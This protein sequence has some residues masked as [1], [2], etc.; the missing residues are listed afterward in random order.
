VER[1]IIRGHFTLDIA[2]DTW[3]GPFTA[4]FLDANGAELQVVPGRA[5]GK[6]IVAEPFEME[7]TPVA[8]G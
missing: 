6:R 1:C 4:T 2:T 5:E 8:N 3:S 7:A